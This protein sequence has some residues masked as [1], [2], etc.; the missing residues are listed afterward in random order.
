MASAR[1]THELRGPYPST[2]R[3]SQ[4]SVSDII[5]LTVGWPV[6]GN[7]TV[8]DRP[9]GEDGR[10]RRHDDRGEGVTRTCRDC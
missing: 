4:E 3:W 7:D 8:G 5:G 2:T 10:L 9:D 1:F 6:H